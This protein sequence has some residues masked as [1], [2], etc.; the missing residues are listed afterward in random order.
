[1]VIVMTLS[2][3]AGAL[4]ITVLI[5]LARRCVRRARGRVG[6]WA[7][8]EASHATIQLSPHSTHFS[9]DN[10]ESLGHYHDKPPR[11]PSFS[12]KKSKGSAS[13]RYGLV[14]K[15]AAS[16]PDDETHTLLYGL[17]AQWRA[18]LQQRGSGHASPRG[19]RGPGH[20]RSGSN[21]S[22]SSASM[23]LSDAAQAAPGDVDVL[24]EPFIDAFGMMLRNLLTPVFG[25]TMVLAVKN[26]EG[27]IEK[28]PPR[29]PPPAAAATL[30]RGGTRLVRPPTPNSVSALTLTLT[31]HRSPLTF[32][33]HPHQVRQALVKQSAANGGV[34]P[35]LRAVLSAER[36]QGM[37]APGKLADPSAAVA[38]LWMHRSLAFQ[39][40]MLDGL[41]S[42]RESKL[43]DVAR[44]AY[45]KHLEANHSWLL[46]NTF[47]MSLNSM[48]TRDELYSRLAPRMRRADE[49]EQI[50][51]QEI[52]EFSLAAGPVVQ[53]IRSIFEELGLSDDKKA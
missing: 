52:R 4:L 19:E 18:C 51:L 16:S 34:P 26:D 47:K 29:H 24:I 17:I 25:T 38:L 3:T 5:F 50:C 6:K 12:E 39:H 45:T 30:P 41:C 40:A 11:R 21:M 2:A 53:A 32:H 22:S 33:P 42:K 8:S 37:H 28:V 27:N 14:G 7:D 46:K 35:T 9:D 23:L 43:S 1:M 48:P 13:D 31:P 36:A 49:R 44:E 15:H 20:Q 10:L